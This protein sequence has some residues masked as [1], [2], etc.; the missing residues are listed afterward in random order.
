MHLLRYVQS[1]TAA[2]LLCK[3]PLGCITSTSTSCSCSWLLLLKLLACPLGVQE[4]QLL[5]AERRL[6]KCPRV[7]DN[8]L[9]RCKHIYTPYRQQPIKLLIHS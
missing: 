2:Q 3:L 4:L 6:H 7:K 8:A 5:L 9:W 1:H